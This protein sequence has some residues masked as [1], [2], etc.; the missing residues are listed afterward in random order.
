[1]A[2]RERGEVELKAG[3][4]T[5]TLRLSINA[6]AEIENLLDVGVNDIIAMMMKPQNFRINTWRAVL[7]GALRE[8]HKGSLEDAGEIMLRAGVQP[9]VEVLSEALRLA[10]P[11]FTGGTAEN[12][13][14]ASRRAGKRS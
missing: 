9:T 11:E 1:M 8:N 14:K 12:P 3:D 10:F 2:N 7:W 5:F 4:E 6:L 13:P